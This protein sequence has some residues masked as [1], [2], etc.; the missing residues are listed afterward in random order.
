LRDSGYPV[1]DKR[2]FRSVDEK[3]QSGTRRALPAALAASHG[4]EKNAK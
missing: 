2:L 1:D 3:A 4:S